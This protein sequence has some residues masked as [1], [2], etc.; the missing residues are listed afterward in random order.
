MSLQGDPSGGTKKSFLHESV[1]LKPMAMKVST[2]TPLCKSVFPPYS[3]SCSI[4]LKA[5]TCFHLRTLITRTPNMATTLC[6]LTHC[7]LSHSLSK[8]PSLLI[9]HPLTRASFILP[10][11]SNSV[12]TSRDI[13]KTPPFWFAS[14]YP[15]TTSCANLARTMPSGKSRHLAVWSMSSSVCMC[16]ANSCCLPKQACR[17]LPPARACELRMSIS[18]SF[19]SH[20]IRDARAFNTCQMGFALC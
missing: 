3:S 5:A 8:P 12:K 7:L 2:Y 19:S 1:S 9:P 6:L 15:I 11:K 16:S 13:D 14:L 18:V 17:C 4:L 10:I 20:G